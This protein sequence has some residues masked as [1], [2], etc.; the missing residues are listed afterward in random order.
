MDASFSR[1]A[2]Y[3]SLEHEQ[4]VVVEIKRGEPAS[5][6]RSVRLSLGDD[7]SQWSEEILSTSIATGG[8]N[9]TA[10]NL[11]AKWLNA[12]TL[13]LC[14]FGNDEKNQTITLK[15]PEKSHSIT[16]NHCPL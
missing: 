14:L 5:K 9:V 11:K 7:Y 16:Q 10:D 15:L 4:V 2:M 3:Q 12:D 6:R 8:D 13:T 1:L